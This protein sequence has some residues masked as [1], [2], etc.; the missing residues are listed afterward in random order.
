MTTASASEMPSTA[1]TP[2][3]DYPAAPR[4][5]PLERSWNPLV[6]LAA[7]IYRATVGGTAPIYVIFARAPRLILAHL[8]LLS[9]SEYGLSLDKRTRALARVFG[10]RV[11]GCIFCDD[12]ETRLAV[13]HGAI[14]Q[15]DADALPHYAASERFSERER[16]VLRYVEELNTTRRASDETFEAL[17]SVLSEREIVELTWLNGVGN[18][19]NL[20]AKPMGLL[21]EG[22][23]EIPAARA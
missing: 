17:R 6:W 15:A 14:A 3:E 9:T 13:K 12:L 22:R 21:P 18:Y 5:A 20:M 7:S 23:C 19:L 16:A 10:S 8:I 4:L 1:S 11:N 2:S